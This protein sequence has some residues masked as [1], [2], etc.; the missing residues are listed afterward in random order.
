MGPLVARKAAG[1][2]AVGFVVACRVLFFVVSVGGGSCFLWFAG[3]RSG[4]VVTF[5]DFCV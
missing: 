5:C 3:G 4:M 1:G 2:K